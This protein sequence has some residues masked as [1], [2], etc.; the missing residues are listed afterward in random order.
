MRDTAG[1]GERMHEADVLESTKHEEHAAQKQRWRSK[2]EIENAGCF[3]D[4]TLA[5]LR[6]YELRPRGYFI[7]SFISSTI[8]TR[9]NTDPRT[10]TVMAIKFAWADIRIEIRDAR[11]PPNLN[12][13]LLKL[14]ARC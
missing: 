12:N 9:E 8:S 3:E 5:E 2:F 4:D 1:G 13:P 14:N 10:L 6:G 7:S 11:L